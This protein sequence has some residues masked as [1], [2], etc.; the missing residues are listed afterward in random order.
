[1]FTLHMFFF[2]I[3]LAYLI[4]FTI[5]TSCQSVACVPLL[6]HLIPYET[7]QKYHRSSYFI[8]NFQLPDNIKI[9]SHKL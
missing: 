8:Y 6:G 5:N 9:L 2:H 3:R 1:M 7:G 4:Y